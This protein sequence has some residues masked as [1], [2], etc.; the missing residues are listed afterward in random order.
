M[1]A[2]LSAL[3]RKH[4][5]QSRQ[6]S[7]AMDKIRHLVETDELTGLWN[8]RHVIRFL[9]GQ[10]AL[11][12]RGGYCFSICY[13]DLD[14]FKK[15]NDRFGHQSGDLVLQ[16]TSQEMAAQLREIDCLARFGGE[17]FLAVLSQADQSAAEVVGQRLLEK[18]RSLDFSEHLSGLQVTLSVGVA[19]FIPSET[20]DS[21]LHRAD[22]AMYKAKSLGRNQVV[23]AGPQ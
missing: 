18:V 4:R 2:N 8:R 19:V 15:V 1:G 23:V 6:L 17:E 16:K 11:A 7:E 21:L 9:Q 3:R 22:Q 5:K 20:L 12:E 13:L 10:K 14:H